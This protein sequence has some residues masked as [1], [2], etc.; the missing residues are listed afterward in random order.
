V[1]RS[2]RGGE[3]FLTIRH[4]QGGIIMDTRTGDIY[5]EDE[6]FRIESLYP[7]KLAPYVKKM[8]MAPTPVQMLTKKVRRNDMCPCGSGKKFKK[9]CM[10]RNSPA[11][12]Q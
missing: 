7:N 2:T 3:L 11:S 1:L 9:C 8:A 6:V 12:A 10:F 5:D 4:D